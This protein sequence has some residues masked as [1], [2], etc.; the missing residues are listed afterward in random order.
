MRAPASAAWE[1]CWQI[2]EKPGQIFV[3]ENVCHTTFGEKPVPF[4]SVSE[5]KGSR[6]HV[7]RQA[8]PDSDPSK[9]TGSPASQAP[10]AACSPSILQSVVATQGDP[11]ARRSVRQKLRERN[12]EEGGVVHALFPPR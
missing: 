12:R 9:Q 6:A 3:T 1:M 8:R 4:D 7:S 5:S 11:M 10:P 2:N